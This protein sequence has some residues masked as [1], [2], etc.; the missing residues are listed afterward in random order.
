MD[1]IGGGVRS[2]KDLTEKGL[3]VRYKLEFHEGPVKI[4][5]GKKED[6]IPTPV[7]QVPTE[8]IF[9]VISRDEGGTPYDGHAH[10]EAR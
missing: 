9:F 3:C 10:R 1:L 2:M 7:T 8:R 5:L 4:N 6:R